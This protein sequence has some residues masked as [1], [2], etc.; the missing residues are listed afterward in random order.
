MLGSLHSLQHSKTGDHMTLGKDIGISL[1]FLAGT[2]F[3]SGVAFLFRL[4]SY[5]V[6]GSVAI[7]G[8]IG[9][10]AGLFIAKYGLRMNR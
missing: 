2:T 4:Q 8:M 9:A 1:G 3:G 6:M 7:F 10:F 5:G